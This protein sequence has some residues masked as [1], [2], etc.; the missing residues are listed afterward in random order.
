MATIEF[1]Q[2]YIIII[3]WIWL[4]YEL[5]A[6]MPVIVNFYISHDIIGDLSIYACVEKKL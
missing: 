4:A 6:N 2:G 3:F 5:T 1:L